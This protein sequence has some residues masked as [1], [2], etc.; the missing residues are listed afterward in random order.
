MDKLE[1]LLTRRVDTWAL[2]TAIIDKVTADGRDDLTMDET[3]HF[4]A[5]TEQ[6]AE[7]DQQ[8]AE[9]REDYE[10]SGRGNPGAEAAARANACG[11]NS[12]GGGWAAR[13]A[14]ALQKMG[15]ESRAVTSGSIDVPQLIEPNI[16]RM[17]RPQRLIDLLTSRK[18]LQSNAFEFYRQSVR[19]NAAAPVADAATKPTSTFT[20][21]P[22]TDRAR[23]IA[24]LSEP[25]PLRLFVDHDELVNFLSSELREGVLDALE[26]EAIQGDGTGE[27]MAGLLHTT[28][29]T[30]VDFDTDVP[31]T[32]RGAVTALQLAGVTPTGWVMHPN[33]AATIDLL[34]Y[35]WGGADAADAGFLLD[36]FQNGTTGS[37]NVFGPTTPRVVSPSIPAGTAILGDWAQL[38]LYVKEDVRI[39]VDTSGPDLFDKNLVKLRGE[40]RFGIGVLRPAS[41][42]VVDLTA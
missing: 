40:G 6:L 2:R 35:Q 16:T 7:I 9:T 31:T 10:R 41:F 36:G 38:R 22:V 28:G 23:V 15:G 14:T 29:V 13:A 8:I 5:L 39:D 4:D 11:G 24:H 30:A 37:G 1:R 25:V 20:V 34:R 12:R 32:L 27:H 33:D 19:T 18:P 21:D 42:A 3:R 17:A 26:H